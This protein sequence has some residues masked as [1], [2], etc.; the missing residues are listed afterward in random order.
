[1]SRLGAMI[2]YTR[3]LVNGQDEEEA[4]VAMIEDNTPAHNPHEEVPGDHH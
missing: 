1:M 4:G 2:A 3:M